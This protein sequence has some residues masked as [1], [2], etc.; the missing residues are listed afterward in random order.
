MNVRRIKYI[1]EESSSG[2]E[3][4]YKNIKDLSNQIKFYLENYYS[5]EL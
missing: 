4:Q 1:D 2:A 3:Y 5:N